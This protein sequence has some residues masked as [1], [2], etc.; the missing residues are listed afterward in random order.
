MALKMSH[1]YENEMKQGMFLVDFSFE[2]AYM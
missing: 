1:G 2:N